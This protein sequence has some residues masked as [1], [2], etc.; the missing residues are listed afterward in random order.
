MSPAAARCLRSSFPR[1]RP[2]FARNLPNK[3]SPSVKPAPA[4]ALVLSLTVCGGVLARDQRPLTPAESERVR[5]QIDRRARVMSKL[6]AGDVLVLWSAPTRVYSEDIN[7]EY[8]QES[9]FRYLTGIAEPN[10]V[11]VM[12]PGA[13]T[14]K[15]YLFID[16]TDP[17]REL[18]FGHTLTP[19]EAREQ[20][21]IATVVAQR[22]SSESDRLIDGL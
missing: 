1:R 15:E 8:R 10:A 13:R 17:V 18:W 4:L 9:H 2:P 20:S 6:S 19:T 3:V 14:Q 11:L 16:Q 22:D 12:V 7:Y 21:G 5:D